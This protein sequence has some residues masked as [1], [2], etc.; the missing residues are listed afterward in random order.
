MKGQKDKFLFPV[1]YFILHIRTFLNNKCSCNTV[2]DL[3]WKTLQ[4]GT[5]P[6]DSSE[7]NQWTPQNTT[8]GLLRTQTMDSSEHN[9]WTPQNTNTGLLRTQP[10]DSSEH[11]QWTPQN[12]T[13]VSCSLFFF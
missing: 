11:N 7:H 6:V 1:T 13:A 3:H 2:D 12:T 9:Q 4:A 5:Q 8:N 10:M